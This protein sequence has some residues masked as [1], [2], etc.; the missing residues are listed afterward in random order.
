MGKSK[1]Y[2]GHRSW[3]AWNVSLWINNDEPLYRRAVDL[4]LRYGR[5]RA[6]RKLAAELTGQ[7][8]P[9]GAKYNQTCIWEAMDGITQ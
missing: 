4:V 1:E 9:D 3:N 6:S 5:G 2:Q 7:K 8:T